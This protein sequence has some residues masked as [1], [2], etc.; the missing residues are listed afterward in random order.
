VT[1]GG[2]T[3]AAHSLYVAAV[4]GTDLDVATAIWT[5]KAPGCAY[6]GNTTVTVTDPNSGY[7]VPPT[8]SV[9]FERPASLPVLFEVTIINS[10]Q[11]PSNAL[12]LV[13][14]AIVNAF[15][16]GDGGPR[17]RIAST[18]LATRFVAPVV[19]LGSW[20][21]VQQIEV[22]SANNTDAATFT[23]VI[24]GTNL[25]TSAVV[26]TILV[27]QT[28]LGAGVEDGTVILSQSSGPAGGAGVYVIGISQ[29]VASEAMASAEA[30]QVS[31]V[32]GYAQAPTIAAANVQLVLV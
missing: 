17:A 15:G 29:T 3:L 31:V 22:G 19:A 12:A 26:G 32:V 18:I 7:T 13:Q 11:V 8:Y 20:A 25:T 10:A 5:K 1:V 24:A 9:T 28:V 21:Q 2:V 4:G 27:G 6:N 16:G 30:D 23:G 14:A